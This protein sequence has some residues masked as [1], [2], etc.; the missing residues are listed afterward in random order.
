M[1]KRKG[2]FSSAAR[3][4]GK[5][6]SSAILMGLASHCKNMLTCRVNEDDKLPLF[7]CCFKEKII[8]SYRSYIYATNHG[9]W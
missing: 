4:V 6:L 1:R 7:H 5:H 8:I 2:K 3:G 9:P